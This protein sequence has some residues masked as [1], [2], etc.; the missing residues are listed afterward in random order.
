MQ[1]KTKVSVTVRTQL[2]QEVERVAGDASR[3]AIFDQALAHWLQER[4]QAQLEQDIES[5]YKSLNAVEKAE[6]EAWAQS[7]D[8]TV[9]RVWNDPK[10]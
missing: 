3:S 1:G 2:L 7:S 5:Y 9:E 6:D 4:R 10:R 8:D